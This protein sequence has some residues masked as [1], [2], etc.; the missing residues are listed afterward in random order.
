MTTRIETSKKYWQ[1]IKKN[2]HTMKSIFPSKKRA[3]YPILGD[4]LKEHVGCWGPQNC[5]AVPST[6]ILGNIR[7]R[8]ISLHPC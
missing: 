6:Y 2:T 4:G 3:K 7:S 8:K 5:S 1:L